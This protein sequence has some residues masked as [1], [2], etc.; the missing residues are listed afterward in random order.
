MSAADELFVPAQMVNH[1]LDLMGKIC[2]YVRNILYE[3]KRWESM[4]DRREPVAKG[5]T[6]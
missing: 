1:C 2:V 3:V 6:G 5:M 4:S